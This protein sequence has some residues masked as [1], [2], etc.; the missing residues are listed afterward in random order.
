M[1]KLKKYRTYLKSYLNQYVT[2]ANRD[3]QLVKTQLFIDAEQRTYFVVSY[4]WTAERF[5]H[6]VAF[7]LQLKADGT[8]WL[9]ENRT[10]KSVVEGLNELGVAKNDIVLALV[11]PYREE[12]VA[13]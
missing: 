1:D 3:D 13:A 6:F 9:Y 7:H 8:I 10:N 4:G 12:K 5:V 2:I 11:E